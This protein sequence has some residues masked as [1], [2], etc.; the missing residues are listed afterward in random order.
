V[1]GRTITWRI[2]ITNDSPT[3]AA[4]VNVVRVSER[5][6]R[7]K[8]LSLTPSRGSCAPPSCNLGRLAAGASATIT[9]VT[10]AVAVGRVLNVVRVGS[11][12]QESDYLNNVA[13]ALV[14]I[15]EPINEARR[16][17]VKAAIATRF[18]NTLTA[19]PRRL[20]SGASSIILTTARSRFGVPLPGVPVV[21]EGNGL[22]QRATTDRGGTA[23]FALT[24]RSVGLVHFR[25]AGI[26]PA[27]TTCR[28]LLAVLGG[29]KPSVTG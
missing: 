10:E 2:T 28:T 29:R 22:R 27:G 14:R 1:L 7:L 9:A 15:V 8:V 3:D 12:E 24:P 6:Y 13:S 16:A 11:E 25:R 26:A 19:S 18:C 23:H 21:A 4:D 20:L 17:G 5:S